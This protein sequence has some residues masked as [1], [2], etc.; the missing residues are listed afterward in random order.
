MRNTGY[1]WVLS[2]EHR[3]PMPAHWSEELKRWRLLGFEGDV[4]ADQI[5]EIVMEFFP[6]LHPV[7]SLN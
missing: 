1:H 4:P 5:H 2:D 3:R 6:Q 7:H